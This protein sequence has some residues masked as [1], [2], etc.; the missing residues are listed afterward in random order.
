MGFSAEPQAIAK[1]YEVNAAEIAAYNKTLTAAG[2]NKNGKGEGWQPTG[3]SN[4][5]Q[6]AE[7]LVTILAIS[8]CR[9][10]ITSGQIQPVMKTASLPMMQTAATMWI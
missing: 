2:E 5:Y 9:A 1:T 10:S 4:E 7:I 8:V 3:N 6:L